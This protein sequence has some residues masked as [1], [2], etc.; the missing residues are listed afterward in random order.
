MAIPSTKRLAILALVVGF[1]TSATASSLRDLHFGEALFYAHQ[2]KFFDALELLDAEIA[3]HYRVD[4]RTLDSLIHH[5]G[6]AEFS[7]GDFELSY[8][9]HHRAGRAIKAVLEAD[10]SDAVRNDAAYRLARIHFQKDQ[11]LDAL[12]VLDAMRGE[13]PVSLR[14]DVEFLRANVYLALGRPAEAIAALEPVQGAESLLGFSNYN[15]GIAHLRNGMP[16]K[17]ERQLDRAG[18][19]RS[20]DPATLAIRDKSNLVLGTILLEADEFERAQGFFDRVRLNGPYSNQALLRAGRAD[21]SAERFERALV[22]WSVLVERDSTD[23]AVQEARLA[24]PY[25]YGKLGVHGRAAVLYGEAVELYRD[26]LR[27]LDASIANVR[28]GEFLKALVREEIRQDKDWVVR[29]RSL[30]GAPETFYLVGLMASH[31]FQTA[32]Q[33]YLDLDDLRDRLASFETSLAAF[34]DVIG[35]RRVYY[36]P[37]LPEVDRAFRRLDAQVRLRIEQRDHVRERLEDMLTAPRTQALATADEQQMQHALDGLAARLSN[38]NGEDA[39]ALRARIGRLKGLLEFR[40]ETEYH[41]RLTRTHENLRALE[42]DVANLQEQYDAFVRTRQAARHSYVGYDD[43]ID[44]LGARVAQ[45]LAR[46]DD[47]MK[48]QGRVLETVAIHELEARRTRL[49]DFQNQARFA[50]ADSYD[51]ASKAQAQ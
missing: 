13:V 17:A 42:L 9:M 11:P 43:L 48:S 5:I 18:R 10:V 51:R 15:L 30:P 34:R 6:E 32:L 1:A 45:N 19:V 24:L 8:R 21:L 23:A 38:R 20:K 39:D 47:V 33:N 35:L 2:E 31:D 37:R 29:L 44:R 14:A 27:K 49:V 7:V 3:Q 4:E 41:D 22:P 40:L 12:R 16:E 36:E 26:E 46:I 50:Y 28:S 25:A